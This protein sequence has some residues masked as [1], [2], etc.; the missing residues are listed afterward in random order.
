MSGFRTRAEKRAFRM[1]R[2]SG[3]KAGRSAK[4]NARRRRRYA[5]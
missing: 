1:G 2:S 3:Y 5:Y 4:R